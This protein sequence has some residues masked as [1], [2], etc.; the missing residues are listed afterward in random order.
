MEAINAGFISAFWEFVREGAYERR[1]VSEGERRY[2]RFI[3]PEQEDY[4]MQLEL[5]SRKPDL[6]PEF[7]GMTITPNPADE[8]LSSLSAILMD[9]AYYQFTVASAVNMEG[10]SMAASE[11]LICLKAKAYL[12]LWSRKEAGEQVDTKNIAKHKNDVF[13]LAATLRGD[14]TIALPEVIKE[15]LQQFVAVLEVEKHDLK[16]MFKAMGIFPVEA[17]E[18]LKQLKLVFQLDE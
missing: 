13:R 5:F 14:L 6:M 12:D 16:A 18:L 7:P 10:A 9:D 3:K 17:Q 11:A 8:D 15:D 4:P 1:Q 2:Y